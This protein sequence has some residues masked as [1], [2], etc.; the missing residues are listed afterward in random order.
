MSDMMEGGIC[1]A[2][3]AMMELT[4]LKRGVTVLTERLGKAQDYL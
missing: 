3:V 1:D 2:N 4:D